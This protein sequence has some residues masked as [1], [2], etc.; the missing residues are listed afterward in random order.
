MAD[1]APP[2]ERTD[3]V[4]K[5]PFT[6]EGLGDALR[7]AR[8]LRPYRLKFAGALL[9]LLVANLLASAEYDARVGSVNVRRPL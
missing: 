3:K 2:G 7:M 4:P 9:A 1:D 6:R 8:Y 5:A